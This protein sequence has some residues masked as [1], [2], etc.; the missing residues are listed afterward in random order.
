MD[1]VHDLQQA[2]E[3]AVTSLHEQVQQGLSLAALIQKRHAGDGW[4]VFSELRNQ[5]GFG[6]SRSAD[7]A[8]LGLWA[9]TKYEFHLYEVKISRSDV[10]REMKDPTKANAVGKYAHHWWL[11]ISDEKIIKDVL[12]PEAW[13]ILVPTVRGGSRMLTEYRKAP[14]LKPKPFDPL[15]CVA[16]LRN[17][18]T[19]WVTPAKHRELQEQLDRLSTKREED[20]DMRSELAQAKRRVEQLEAAITQFQE[21]SG[22]D[23]DGVREGRYR[24]APLARAVKF[25]LEND[26]SEHPDRIRHQVLRA[27]REA[28]EAM[29][30]ALSM[31]RR[32]GALR[33]LAG[34][35]LRHTQ[36]CMKEWSGISP[37]QKAA[38]DCTCGAEMSDVEKKLVPNG[39]DRDS[40]EEVPAAVVANGNDDS[41][42]G[43]H[44]G[45]AREDLEDAGSVLRD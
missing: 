2:E 25:A 39:R 45:G 44:R 17:M 29:Q 14:K 42:S 8:A 24:V 10:I 11:V 21:L 33:E 22:V 36:Q 7:H 6:A 34:A 27:S 38:T 31:A 3:S 5:P 23:M 19:N 12:I 16:M 37:A 9:S 4:F 18:A 32:A 40:Q 43:E 1:E 41:G 35:P 26:I 15:F 20:P 28:D 13:G 30:H